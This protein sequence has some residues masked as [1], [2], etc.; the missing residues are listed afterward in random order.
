MIC[1]NVTVNIAQEQANDWLE[2]MRDVQLPRVLAAG[3]VSGYRLL[4]IPDD[5][6]DESLTFATQYNFPSRENFELFKQNHAK[7]M[8]T[9]QRSRFGQD[10]VAIRTVME[11]LEQ[12]SFLV[13]Q[14]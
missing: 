2:W 3:L 11:V 12:Q 8:Q 14:S 10:F 13:S 1:Y 5:E 4:Y 6:E 7:G 9:A